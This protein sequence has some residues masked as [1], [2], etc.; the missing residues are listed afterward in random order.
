MRMHMAHIREDG[1]V[2]TAAEH[3]RSAAEYAAKSLK[4]IGIGTTAFLAALLHDFG[5]F[6]REYDHY[7]EA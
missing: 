3:C 1:K 6:K 7:L 5:K 2:Q 4:P